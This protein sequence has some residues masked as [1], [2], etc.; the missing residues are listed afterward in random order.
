MCPLTRSLIGHCPDTVGHD[1]GVLGAHSVCG[2]WSIVSA[3]TAARAVE[4]GERGVAGGERHL[5][6]RAAG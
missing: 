6:L 1:N 5:I 3:G 2:V 4:G